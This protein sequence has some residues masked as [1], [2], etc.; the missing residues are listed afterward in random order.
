VLAE[1]RQF[2]IART[3]MDPWTAAMRRGDFES[4]WS[5]SDEILRARLASGETCWHWPR[6]LQYVWRGAAFTG[7]RAL[8][9]CYHGLGDIIQFIRFAAPLR[10]TAREVIVWAPPLLLPLLATVSGVDRVLPLHDGTPEADYDL[11]MEIME[12]PH[13]LRITLATL[14]PAVP[15]LF[16]PRLPFRIWRD[17]RPCI[18]LVWKAGDWDRRRSVPARLLA[19]LG[20]VEGLR[21]MSLQLGATAGELAVIGAEDLSSQDVITTASRIRELDLV[22]AADTMVAHLAGA[23]GAPAWTLLHADC[24]WRWMERR[25][26]SPW[27]PSMRLFRQPWPG[28]WEPVIEEVSMALA[29]RFG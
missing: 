19:R 5:I 26:D 14:P 9:R 4:A 1:Q 24:D 22:I 25:T 27:Y 3:A 12:L 28:Q 17:S 29:E 11:D 6:H 15:Y 7:A 10:H 8:V 18:G 23:L 16:P 20:Q 21:L 2:G 13:A